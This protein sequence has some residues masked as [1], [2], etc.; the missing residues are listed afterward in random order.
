MR[1]QNF[2]NHASAYD[3]FI[4][5]A[6]KDGADIAIGIS[7]YLETKGVSCWIAPR[8]V[9][10]GSDY[11]SEIILGIK[12][13]KVFVLLLTEQA[14]RS[15]HVAN[16]VDRA[17]HYQ[18]VIIPV[19]IEQ[20]EGIHLQL[21]TTLEYYL[22]KTHWINTTV[23]AIREPDHPR[24]PVQEL[25]TKCLGQLS[26]VPQHQ[27][28]KSE[29][30]PQ[31][32]P[33]S[34]ESTKQDETLIIKVVG[35]SSPPARIFKDGDVATGFYFD[36]MNAIATRQNMRLQF[37]CTSFDMSFKMLKMGEAH[38]MIGP[39][40]TPQREQ[41]FIFS[42]LPLRPAKKVFYVSTS[43]DPIIR[44]EDLYGYILITMKNTFYS[45]EIATDTK[46]VRVEITNYKTGIEMIKD[47]NNTS[48][49][50]V[51]I[52]PENQGDFLLEELQIDL[53]KSPF[54]IQGNSSY[55]IYSKQTPKPAITA[56]EEGLKNIMDDNTYDQI[57]CMY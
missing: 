49:R 50:Y 12:A 4:S 2:E 45:K 11:A 20:R 19:K 18:K 51:L 21:S 16:E 32:A 7:Q 39:N 23:K 24:H 55:I 57:L 5:Y 17:F 56:I 42:N 31:P 28:Q 44:Y 6:S 10:P 30:H 3:A 34:C 37:I 1:Q 35:N 36:I 47:S 43:S 22:S 33:K 48:K 53:V 15:S 14:N 25:L 46:L 8:N 29:S 54:Y 27:K 41:D 9:R 26:S 40:K 38:V 52:M 13:C